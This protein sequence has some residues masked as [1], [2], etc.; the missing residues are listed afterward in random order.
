[1]TKTLI[2]SFT[3]ALVA[4]VTA[5]LFTSKRHKNDIRKLAIE[6]M[7]AEYRAFSDGHSKGWDSGHDHALMRY[8]IDVYLEKHSIKD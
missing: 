6:H 5:L 1:M 4:A 3:A 8:A 2:T 7:N